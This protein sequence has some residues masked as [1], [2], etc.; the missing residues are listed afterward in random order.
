LKNL[1]YDPN[2][3]KNL[4]KLLPKM[5]NYKIFKVAGDKGISGTKSEQ[6]SPCGNCMH[7]C[8]MKIILQLLSFFPYK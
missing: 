7:K 8:V 5:K 6:Q 1:F 2:K 3:Q 4:P